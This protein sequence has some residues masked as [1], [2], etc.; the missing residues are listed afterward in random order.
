MKLMW[1]M[2]RP[3]RREDDQCVAVVRGGMKCGGWVPSENT[4]GA[5]CSLPVPTASSQL[6]RRLPFTFLLHLVLMRV[7]SMFYHSPKSRSSNK[8]PWTSSPPYSRLLPRTGHP[9]KPCLQSSHGSLHL[10]KVSFIRGD[11]TGELCQVPIC[12]FEGCSFL[13]MSLRN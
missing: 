3:W 4:A 7:L 11:G 5:A 13:N 2:H 1:V 10:R 9:T 6:R 12:S 8:T